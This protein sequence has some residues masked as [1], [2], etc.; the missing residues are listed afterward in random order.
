MSPETRAFLDGVRH[1]DDPT[2]EDERR[3]LSAVVAAVATGALVG[4]AVGASKATKL[5]AFFGISGLK[6]GGVLVG[7]G[8]LSWTLGW[9]VPAREPSSPGASAPAPSAQ[10]SNEPA[11]PA[12]V[13]K[14]IPSALEE[15]EKPPARP[16]ASN[17]PPPREPSP[18]SLRE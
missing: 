7:L 1:A 8:A 9:A 12:S 18:A 10:R 11:P 14:P 15:P 5:S 17:E 3:V 13:S 16:R 2:P 4:G 6:L